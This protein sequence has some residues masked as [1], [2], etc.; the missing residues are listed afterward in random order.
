LRVEESTTFK[1]AF[2]ARTVVDAVL[3]D[4]LIA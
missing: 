1:P 3:E 2:E 4:E